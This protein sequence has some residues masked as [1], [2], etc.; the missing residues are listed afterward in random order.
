[1]TPSTE[2]F[3][4]ALAAL[5][6]GIAI[7]LLLQLYLVLRDLRRTTSVLHRRLDRTLTDLG[8][9]VAEIKHATVSTPPL[10][11]QLVAAIPAVLA[12]MRAFRTGMHQED[13]S[14]HPQTEESLP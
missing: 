14:S 9:V 5:M 13:S 11:A 7:P 12:A 4:V 10:S 2:V 6:S 8:D 3:R 1:M